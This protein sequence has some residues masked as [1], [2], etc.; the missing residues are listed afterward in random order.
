VSQA[1]RALGETILR[2]GIARSP[3]L[4]QARRLYS[5]VS[6][7]GVLFGKPKMLP[8]RDLQAVV[9]D[10]LAPLSR[11]FRYDTRCAYPQAK[12]RTETATSEK[13]ADF[14]R[15]GRLL[16]AALP[17][18]SPGKRQKKRAWRLSEPL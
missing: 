3:R 16:P 7:S 11:C 14:G 12:R 18:A 15:F 17:R 5:A 13:V 10:E 9:D 6:K 8:S 1:F 4:L 2:V